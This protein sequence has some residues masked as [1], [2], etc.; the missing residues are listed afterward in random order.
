MSFPPWWTNHVLLKKKEGL[1]YPPVFKHGL[2]ENPPFIDDF[3]SY[4]PPPSSGIAQPR[5]MT[6]E[7]TIYHHLPHWLRLVIT[8]GRDRWLRGVITQPM[9][10]M[11]R[12]FAFREWR[13]MTQ[14]GCCRYQIC[15]PWTLH[16]AES[17]S[18]QD[19]LIW[20]YCLLQMTLQHWSSFHG[21][22]P[23]YTQRPK[24]QPVS[25][26]LWKPPKKHKKCKSNDTSNPFLMIY[27][28]TSPFFYVKISDSLA[29]ST[30]FMFNSQYFPGKIPHSF[31]VKSMIKISIF[32][33]SNPQFKGIA[34]QLPC[35]HGLPKFLTWK[36]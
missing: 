18:V 9:V 30:S 25:K 19:H 14:K 28:Q 29:T 33:E 2:Q 13:K 20:P 23:K 4:K 16:E 3:P 31:M 6:L 12:P 5:L 22:Q 8:G 26:E 7:G 27:W 34:S 17:C 32:H 21:L 11:V 10:R 36:R 24:N 35:C 15:Q 1:V